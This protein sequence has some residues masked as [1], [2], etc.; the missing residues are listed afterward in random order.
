MLSGIT[1]R[2]VN[3]DQLSTLDP[4]LR[5]AITVCIAGAILAVVNTF[6]RPVVKLLSLPL[7][8]LT[9]GL[10]FVVINAFMLALTA[11]ISAQLGV[12]I[13]IESF[14]WALAGGILISVVNTALDLIVPG[15][16]R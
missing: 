13:A 8:I 2:E 5:T 1:L 4:R 16:K 3:F 9:L 11:W 6:I 10:I 14:A 7:Y 15:V 12:G